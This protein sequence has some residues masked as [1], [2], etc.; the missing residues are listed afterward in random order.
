MFWIALF[1]FLNHFSI[2]HTP[3]P[4]FHP[5]SFFSS[6]MQSLISF[7]SYT[8][9]Y[10]TNLDNSVHPFPLHLLLF[11]HT[12]LFILHPECCATLFMLL[13]QHINAH[14]YTSFFNSSHIF[15]SL[16]SASMRLSDERSLHSF[17]PYHTAAQPALGTRSSHCS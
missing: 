2:P 14:N 12:L 11:L 8:V 5:N 10:I 17:I 1:M 13:F 3:N 6:Q 7:K 15:D 4:L 16:R 9:S